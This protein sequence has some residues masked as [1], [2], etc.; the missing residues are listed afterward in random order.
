MAAFEEKFL[1]MQRPLADDDMRL[2]EEN[3][4]SLI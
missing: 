1:N 4:W 3:L 2:L